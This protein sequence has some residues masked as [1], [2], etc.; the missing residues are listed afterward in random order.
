M[1][2]IV[3]LGWY[4]ILAA[5]PVMIAVAAIDYAASYNRSYEQL[6]EPTASCATIR[7]S[8]KGIRG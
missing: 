5:T 6:S 8:R 2:L 1:A 7:R 3:D 4:A